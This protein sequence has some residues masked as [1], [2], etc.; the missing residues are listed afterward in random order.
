MPS[1]N[2]VSK[3]EK[4]LSLAPDSFRDCDAKGG[5]IIVT[6]KWDVTDSGSTGVAIY[7]ESPGNDRK[8]WLVGGASGESQT[9]KWVF[10]KSKFTMLDKES[11]K[12]LA[13]R[14][15]VAVPCQ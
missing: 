12:L 1:E 7:V 13:Q 14:A 6:A 15:V 11:G 2:S 5:A 10:D 8:L 3:N 4:Y 9:G